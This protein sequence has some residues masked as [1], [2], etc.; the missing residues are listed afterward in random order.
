MPELTPVRRRYTTTPRSTSHSVS[1][2][3]EFIKLAL[4]HL[5][6]PYIYFKRTLRLEAAAGASFQVRYFDI[7]PENIPSET[8]RKIESSL[9]LKKG[10]WLVAKHVAQATPEILEMIA[11]MD[12]DSDRVRLSSMVQ[13]M[14]ILAHGSLRSHAN[15]VQLLGFSWE[16]HRDEL[17]RRWPVLIMEAADC[18]SLKHFL[19]LA[20]FSIKTPAFGASIALDIASGLEALHS[21]GVVH[22]DLKP[23]NILIFQL[24][25]EVFR[26]KISDFGSA[27]LIGDLTSENLT[28]PTRVSLPAFSPPWEAPEAF[29]EILLEDL[30]KVD[31]YGFGL[32]FCHLTASGADV[33][34]DFRRRGHLDETYEG[35]DFDKIAALKNDSEAMVNH[36]KQFVSSKLHMANDEGIR[37][38]QI[39]D[40]TLDRLPRNR[41]NIAEIRAILCTAADA[42]QTPS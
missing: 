25:R 8:L 3:A 41:R 12:V 21:C 9:K 38:S 17:N 29:E 2:P 33:F 15:I 26:A 10:Q 20:D 7:N 22:G 27:S 36:A 30:P 42:E 37:F 40:S 4:D 14:R 6:V 5:D 32:L 11:T 31:V 28:K 18:G 13:E 35:Y 39:I 34:S 24:S 19:E 16:M 23:E 1:G